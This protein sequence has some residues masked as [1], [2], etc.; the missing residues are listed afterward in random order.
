MRRREFLRAG[1][2]GLSG[3]TLPE[4]F[5][6]RARASS[7]SARERTALIVVWLQGGASHLET[8][9]P[10]PDAPAE[11]R[12]PFGS[13]ATKA[14]GVRISELLPLHAAV[15]DRFT[16]LR[17]LA[18]TGF[19]HQQGNQQMFTGHP[20]Q[21]LKH[22]PEHPD[23]M[24]IAH[25]IR[26]EPGRRVPT[27]VGV[28]PIPYLG[29]AYL[30]PAFEPF[31]VYGDPNA[32]EFSVPG[33]GIRNSAEVGRIGS[34]MNLSKRFDTLRRAVDD[35]MQSESFDAFQEQAYALLA[36]PEARLAFNLELEDPRLRDRYGRNTW[37]Q[38]CLLARRLV[39]A[40][41]DLVTTSLDGPLC[42]RVGNWDDHA[43]NHHVFDALKARCR[44]FDQAVST[45]VEDLHAR[46]LDRRVLLVVTGE[47]GRTPRISYAKDSASGVT[48][49]GRDH[50]PR[51]VSL[52]LS[53][54]GIPGGQV[55]GSTDHHGADV[56]RRR[57]GVRDLLATIYQ[58]LGIDAANLTLR[59]RTGRPIP[60]LPEGGPIPELVGSAHS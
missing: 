12:G 23:L 40:G 1:F 49:P 39:E 29:S 59:D 53:G 34:R 3:L 42:G 46:G 9:D 43:V 52:L 48:Q 2:A 35:R 50:W 58:H 16:I 8:Y 6:L 60:A 57:V 30:G 20:E 10:K 56:T 55:I 27:Y 28:N 21:V 31:A 38:R 44:Y 19:C 54:G 15:A 33:I 4:L 22:N 14:E 36:G 18:H 45:L 32:P 7:G 17:S 26:S 37:G 25:R 47:F 13:I 41:V 11:I 5:A 51:A 24:C